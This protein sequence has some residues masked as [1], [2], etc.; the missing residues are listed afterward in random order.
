MSD[1]RA[2]SLLSITL[3]P[4]ASGLAADLPVPCIAGSCGP[5]VGSF[6]TSG[7]A[8]AATLGSSL[9][10]DQ[11]TDK[12]ILNWAS[13][14]IAAGR[15]VEFR[16]PT[17]SSIALN[18]IYQANPSQ[19]FGTLEA[20]GQ[21]YLVNQN[22]MIFGAGSKVSAA[23]VVA[24][25]LGISDA[26]FAAGLL[27]PSLLQFGLP[28]LVSDGRQ[29]VLNADG[30]L[31][32]GVDGNLVPVKLLVQ[33]GA[34]LST[35]GSGGRL[36]LASQH[37]ENAGTL[38]AP[39]GGQVV[40]AA[41]EKVYLQASADPALRGLVVEVDAGGTAWNRLTG[42]IS[43]P[44][45]NITLVGLAVNQDGRASATTSVSANGSVRLLARDT[46]AF[47]VTSSGVNLSASRGGTLTVGAGSNVQ[48][49]PDLQDAAMAVD[50][51]AQL[52]STIELSGRQIFVESGAHLLAPGGSVSLVG[53][54][55]P[56]AGAVYDA[57][58]R[59]R[60]KDG[61][62]IDVSGSDATAP[63]SRN[64]V[65]VE[66]RANELKDSPLQRD[67]VLRGQAVVIDA[68]VGTP[69][70]DV[71]GAVATIART[72]AERTVN[73]GTV[74]FV[75]DGDVVVE[76]GAAV[77]VS[78]GRTDYQAGYI[79]TTQLVGADGRVVDIGNADPNTLYAGILNP[80]RK[81]SFDRWGVTSSALGPAIGRYDPG[82]T[83]GGNGGTVSLAAPVLS[84]AGSLR[85]ST[86]AGAFQRDPALA[87][88]GALLR[89]GLQGGIGGSTTG[90]DFRAPSV[91]FVT[92]PSP[93]TIGDAA[94]LLAPR[95]FELPT[96]YLTTGGFRRTEIYS[97]GTVTLDLAAPLHLLPGSSMLLSAQR[98]DLLSSIVAPS[99]SIR[100]SSE[101]TQGIAD[102][103]LSQAGITVGAGVTLD[104]RG[105]WINDVL[106]LAQGGG[107]GSPTWR[108]G[109]S[110]SLA[111]NYFD[112]LMRVGNDAQLLTSGGAWLRS[113]GSVTGGKG[114]SVSL[115]AG[116]PGATLSLGDRIGLAAFGVNGAAGGQFALEAGRVF[117]L[118]APNWASRQQSATGGVA[119]VSLGSGLFSRY[120]FSTFDLRASGPWSGTTFPSVLSVAAGTRVEARTPYLLVNE[121]ALR[122]GDAANLDGL[123]DAFLPPT[124][125]QS[126]SAITLRVQPRE[127]NRPG[128]VG[129]LQIG[130]G[131]VIDTA[132]RSTITLSSPGGVDVAGSLLA[133]AGKINVLVPTPDAAFD[134]GYRP[135]L[136]LTVG[137]GAVLDV[138]GVALTL[139]DDRGLLSG[140]VP[141]G[142]TIN[143]KADRG[144]LFL[145][146]GSLLR[147]DGASGLLDLLAGDNPSG[148]AVR[149]LLGSAAGTIQLQAPEGL[150][151]GGRLSARAGQSDS[152]PVAGGTLAVRLTR[153]RGF[154]PGFYGSTYS[155]DDRVMRVTRGPVTVDAAKDGL[156]GVDGSSLAAAG[157]D[158]VLLESGNR[159]DLD[160]GLNLNLGR[161]LTIDSPGL[162]VRDNGQV[163]LS[164]PYL[165]LGRSLQ[166]L[167]TITPVAGTGSLLLSGSLVDLVGDATVSG[168]SSL[169]I[170][171][172]GDIRAR[173]AES[174]RTSIGSLNVAGTIALRARSLYPT[175]LS[176]YEIHAAGGATNDLQIQQSGSTPAAP[177]SAG[178]SLGLFADRIVQ[179]GSVFAPFG[180]IALNGL[181]SVT[182]APGS[183][184]S[185]SGAGAT[186]PFGSV[187][188]GTWQYA[189]G[190]G[191]LPQAGIPVRRIDVEAPAVVTEAG[192]RIDLRGGGDLY[193]YEW[194]PG[195]GGSRDALGAPAAGHFFAIVPSMVGQGG[196]Y[197]PQESA[198]AGLA[199]G[200]S[201]TLT[202]SGLLPA[203]T[204]P[205]LPA[206]YALLPG[207]VLVEA[208]PKYA[209]LAPG[210]Q[211]SLSDGTPVVAGRRS[212]LGTGIG[213]ALYSGFAIR[214]G[215]YGRSL[216]TYSDNLASQ[217]FAARAT[218]LD[219]PRPN[220]PADA[221]AIGFNVG[222]RLDIQGA[223]A[224]AA[225][226][227]GIGAALDIAASR[228]EL[229][230]TAAATDPTAVQVK[231]STIAQ[232]NPATVLLGGLRN[233][234]GSSIE[235][236]SDSV[237]INQGVDLKHDEVLLVARQ[238]V[239]LAS[240]AV[241]E[242]T[243]ST[244][245]R[246]TDPGF[247]TRLRDVAL[248]GAGS[249]GAAV[250]GVSDL[251]RLQVNR[252]AATAGTSQG[253]VSME[254]GARVTTRSALLLDAPGGTR[255]DGTLSGAGAFWN[256]GAGRLSFASATRVGEL[257]ITPTVE[258]AL[259]A[260]NSARLASSSTVDFYRPVTLGSA[261]LT[262]LTVQAAA[263][264]AM[265]S[266]LNVSLATTQH[267]TL[268]GAP[269]QTPAPATG[270]G[271]L[272]LQT[273]LLD[274]GP[275]T[276]ATAG[277]TTT[278]LQASLGLQGVGT[279]QLLAGG[280][281]AVRAP[282]LTMATAAQTDLIAT[283]DVSV[284]RPAGTV[285]GT[286]VAGGLG[287]ALSIQGR[288]VDLASTVLLPAGQISV[289][290]A[291][292]IS[293]HDG[294]NLT[295]ASA[296]TTVSGRT[297]AAPAG[298]ILL[299]A[300]TT[301]TADST[302]T[303]D[304]SGTADEDAGHLKLVSGGVMQADAR[305]KGAATAGALG[306]YAD[307]QAGSL[308]GFGSLNNQLEAGGFTGGRTVQ[309]ASGDLALAA[310]A[311]LT[312]RDVS[313]STDTGRVTIAGSVRAPGDDTRSS[314]SIWG[315]S[316]VTLTGSIVADAQDGAARG[317]IVTLGTVNGTLDLASGSRISTAGS[318]EDGRV[319]LR[320]P[321][322]GSDVAVSRL[323]AVFADVS[324]LS[325]ESF[326]TVAAPAAPTGA[327]FTTWRQSLQTY[328]GT[329]AP[330]I[331]ARLG[332]PAGVALRVVPGLELD[333]V[334]DLTLGSLDLTGWRFAGQPA[335]L[336]FRATG[337]LTVNGTVSDGFVAW[338]DGVLARVD[339]PT[340]RSGTLR[341][342]AG[343][344]LGSADPLA[345]TGGLSDFKLGTAAIV[346]TATGDLSIAAAR[347]LVFGTRS[348]VF[349][350]GLQGLPT[351]NRD[352]GPSFGYP[353]SGGQVSLR[354]GRDVLGAVVTQAVGDWQPRTG[355]LLA[356]ASRSTPTS[357]GVDVA[358]FGWNLGSLGGGDIEVAAGRDVLNLS[359]A[360]PDSALQSAPDTLDVLA[361]GTLS[362]D[363][364]R[365]VSS[366]YAHLTKGRNV[367]HAGAAFGR[368]RAFGSGAALGS[369]FSVEDAQVVLRARSGLAIESVFN[370]TILSQ[371][372]SIAADLKSFFFT[373]GADSQLDAV[374]AAG[375]AAML[376]TA[377]RL[378]PYI[379]QS[380]V[381]GNSSFALGLVPSTL[382][383]QSLG[384]D[385][386][387]SGSL[388][389][390][391]SDTGQLDL[392]AARDIDAT[393]G[394]Q[395]VQS[396]AEADVLPT[397]LS[398][399][400]L[401]G[402]GLT[403]SQ[404]RAASARHLADPVV[405]QVTAGRDLLGGVYASAKP[406]AVKV[407]RDLS[408]ATLISQ[409]LH[410]TDVSSVLAGRDI[411]YSTRAL[412]GRIEVGGPGSLAVVAGRD[413]D[414]GFSKGI[415]TIGNVVN[416]NL[417]TSHG[418]DLSVIAGAGP[419]TDAVRFLTEV[420]APSADYRAALQAFMGVRLSTATPTYAQAS[421]GFAQLD[422]AGQLPFLSEVFFADLVKSGREVNAD[423]TLGFD[424]GYAAIDA[425]FPGSRPVEGQSA[426]YAGDIRLAFSRIY[427]LSGGNIS[428]FTPGGLLNV[429]LANPPATLPVSR[430]PS[431]LGIVSQKAGDVRIYT[432]GDVLVN[433]SR[434]FTL[435]GGSI[436]AWSTLG[437]IDAGRGSKSAISAPPPR[438]LIDAQGNVQ[439]DFGAAI[440][441]SGIRTIL[442]DESITPGNVD[443]IAPA[444]SV[445]A[446]DAG[447]GSA[448]NL[449]VAA[450]QVVGLDNIQVGGSS[451]GVPSE[452]S[453]LG[454]SLSGASAAGN[455]ASSSS[456]SSVDSKAQQASATPL[457][458]STLAFL[459]AFL[460]GFGDE[461]C[462]STDDECLRRN[463][464][465][466]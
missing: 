123:A 184:T 77:D 326:L 79:Q 144:S 110:I 121:A 53:Q 210:V 106:D 193:A 279:G 89:I 76:K 411:T 330:A 99:G 295:A 118:D 194:T 341:F 452:T 289:S 269:A 208:L 340:D 220:L 167:Q 127:F 172:S 286:G 327:N 225:A 183:L 313:L 4:G 51:Q 6:V 387:L 365:N 134:P 168:V 290:A 200:D 342:A 292:D 435:G 97:N 321:A 95:T 58:S 367:L 243:H 438:V 345:V 105:G 244:P 245:T 107:V 257:T 195:S 339:L 304:V 180:Q 117:L 158:A 28:A 47:A 149:S 434:V 432:S 460:E 417:P 329:A 148:G 459:D 190:A 224:S 142:G 261:S 404:R 274:L 235:L 138:S 446:G 233:S 406:L 100:V 21:V 385:V 25:T 83:E 125:L 280:D 68:R 16:Q 43:A 392:L 305:I 293:L 10:I 283:G 361:G 40:L 288:R 277:F 405:S 163:S 122:T 90:P 170:D 316:G 380:V 18:R 314:V 458:Q 49:L 227:G 453:S 436:A 348:S 408:D 372:S 61:A 376:Y 412:T 448:G 423:P 178:G 354:A 152:G 449:N 128:D 157:F 359:V 252:S 370:P 413:V 389:L 447:I 424:R 126:A 104:V 265:Q 212:F 42:Q 250:L 102:A 308:A 151:A 202:A 169:R 32:L 311:T 81:V 300:G 75:S 14:D 450:Q 302:A 371:G 425:L 429:G 26:N 378:A 319:L 17:N 363:A 364:G 439:V 198:L 165:S 72:V 218:R 27:S 221:G 357:W 353:D 156:D 34:A 466:P 234:D 303:L 395:V 64:L 271:A 273:G 8:S 189:L 219:L 360:A 69:L 19:I 2:I 92:A 422:E 111:A 63:V 217:F 324:D 358:K 402:P 5:L 464:G 229:T 115:R 267:L 399:S 390:F 116:Y 351:D 191:L 407:G 164:A 154:S 186:I 307:I 294:A 141:A 192:S 237:Q 177:L 85:G 222:T 428:L 414:L 240:G 62:V 323:G 352:R 73:G 356:D 36:L 421:T 465:N 31:A 175:T 366:L 239:S 430:A 1:W 315:G 368:Q 251:D 236:V 108:D 338:T 332:T 374:T 383:L 444:G 59:I 306:G 214:S 48:I 297:V 437:D 130:A 88:V 201:L 442:T 232:W 418:A 336:T 24:S 291:Q 259:N 109:G 166:R 346:R 441:G 101:W 113:N 379:G 246:T 98:V 179:A 50:D 206:R 270:S 55:S 56:V 396:D 454:A 381:S 226:A 146:P 216:A 309:V 93:L 362:L 78:G 30:S 160:A 419:G 312:A 253:T 347:D 299:T 451:A 3:V 228:L 103:A 150:W 281:L 409:N 155:D 258:A 161:S 133:P 317:G 431:D 397:P 197:D 45:G 457:A 276:L 285:A 455:A 188:V 94:A 287:G 143:L 416:T 147:A 209:N 52:P 13:F 325:L 384:N 238:G 398:A 65:T 334:G 248:T 296:L 322:V 12:A 260:A 39:N 132:P 373:Y 320:A 91:A 174:A 159:V 272:L 344:L 35:I 403:Q 37:V 9:R 176:T 23:G 256:L 284:A 393:A 420:V 369:L 139:A 60:V 310:G 15:R 136:G 410:D 400:N 137:S 263:L 57:Q 74:S 462:K 67:G 426:P 255:L 41:G 318:E 29:G 112:S 401:I 377:L 427:T 298:I 66:L 207:A 415:T 131:A 54:A 86:L 119:S 46:A 445:N 331:T 268:A 254:A 96:D 335:N 70:A 71:S 185:V 140:T 282:F 266:G 162:L 205:L 203:G 173:G 337:S 171:S 7:A 20:N 328:Y 22:G 84:L 264:R 213:D 223:L 135:D 129:T 461:V 215:S 145:H 124:A 388:T 249:A 350:A 182:F 242:S 278:S 391:A 33:Q 11:T 275:G 394:G 386:K 231:A 333:R 247:D 241:V 443:L 199:T 114:G 38:T 196:V 230:G 433:Q 355:R 153:E 187:D 440:A 343:S 87:P 349:T 211:T 456:S 181:Q 382:R 120:G 262:D 82:Y 375:D 463:T 204:Y 301:L 44:L 80:T